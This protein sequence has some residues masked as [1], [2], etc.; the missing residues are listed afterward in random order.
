VRLLG[1]ITVN[2]QFSFGY[3]SFGLQTWAAGGFKVMDI[4]RI[5]DGFY[6]SDRANADGT[7]A[8]VDE[9]VVQA[10]VRGG[11]DVNVGIASAMVGGGIAGQV[12]FNLNDPN[13]DGKVRLGEISQIE[14]NHGNLFDVSGRLYAEL[15]ATG[16]VFGSPFEITFATTEL[17]RTDPSAH[18][19][20]PVPLP[21]LGATSL[22]FT[23]P[24]AFNPRLVNY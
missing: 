9:M 16:Q 2:A 15:F 12:K 1:S 11:L 20:T 21:D 4:P 8:D 14:R 18:A 7:G 19:A 5:A 23:Q 22:V 3:D 24:N 10:T 13:N 6:V 17:W